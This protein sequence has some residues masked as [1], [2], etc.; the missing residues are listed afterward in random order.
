MLYFHTID[1]F[2][3]FSAGSLLTTEKSLATVQSALIGV[4]TDS[5]PALGAKRQAPSFEQA[6]RGGE[7]VAEHTFCYIHASGKTFTE[8]E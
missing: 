7:W 4:G 5:Q 6:P 3:Q 2:T 1:Q 8:A